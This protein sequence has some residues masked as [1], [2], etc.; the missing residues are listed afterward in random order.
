[1]S[2]GIN[3]LLLGKTYCRIDN[4]TDVPGLESSKTGGDNQSQRDH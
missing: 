1:M 4:K 3:P 2:C